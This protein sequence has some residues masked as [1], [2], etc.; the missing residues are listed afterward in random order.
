MPGVPAGWTD[1]G[2]I[3]KPNGSQY[4]YTQGFRD[5]VL[6]HTWSPLDTPLEDAQSFLEHANP[7]MGSGTSQVSRF[8]TLGWQKSTNNVY[9]VAIG[10]EVMWYR[11]QIANLEAELAAAKATPP[12]A[13]PPPAPKPSYAQQI[14]AVQDA[15]T[16]LDN[17]LKANGEA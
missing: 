16:A 15:V 6:A 5:Y 14:A 17:D 10:Q 1:D 12:P 7:A 11:Q 2:T 8:T 9:V 3:L 4:G 13:P